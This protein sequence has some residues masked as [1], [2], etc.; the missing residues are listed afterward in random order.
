VI[1]VATDPRQAAMTRNRVLAFLKRTGVMLEGGRGSVPNLV[2]YVVGKPVKGN[3]WSHQQSQ[4]IFA[5]TRSVR[6]SPDVLTCR[7]VDGKITFVHRRLWPAL[8]R[9]ASLFP[10]DR[11]AAVQ[12]V[13]TRTGAHRVITVPFPD[14][15]PDEVRAA[16]RAM[17]AAQAV[18][19]LGQWASEPAATGAL[20]S[21]FQRVH[22]R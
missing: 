10:R 2:E 11:L 17:T 14:W 1:D 4:Q 12:E 5:L 16:G 21:A 13:H 18:S 8:V 3:W 15:V 20:V 22:M 9:L 7:V 19:S 6:A